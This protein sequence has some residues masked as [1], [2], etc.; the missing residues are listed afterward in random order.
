[1]RFAPSS[2]SGRLALGA[3]LMIGVALIISAIGIGFVLERFIRG[4]I[5]QRLDGQITSIASALAVEN[6]AL[7]LLTNVDSPPFDQPYSGW[8]W[9]VD[10]GAQKLR[11]ASLMAQDIWNPPAKRGRRQMLNGR[12]A[13]SDGRHG[14]DMHY[15]SQNLTIAGSDVTVTA[16]APRDALMGP[17]LQA[18]WP[19]GAS[20]LLLG[21]CLGLASKF[22]LR[23]GLRPLTALK[24]SLADVRNGRAT[25]IP[26]D[27][28]SELK[29]LVGE[30]NSL[31]D[32]NAEGLSRARL[33]VANL[34]H[35]LNTPLATLELSLREDKKGGEKRISLVRQMQERIRHHLGRARTAVL[36]GPARARTIIAPHIADIASA[37]GKIYADKNLRFESLIK[38]GLS[39]ACEPQDLDEMLGNIL[40]NSFKWAKSKVEITA[41]VSQGSVAL[42]LE[43]DGPG[44]ADDKLPQAL[45]PGRRLDESAPGS[46]FGLSI[47]RELAELYGG[48]IRLSRSELGGL[49]V[50]LV[51]PMAAA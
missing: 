15:R 9:Q 16:T 20:L 46:G 42:T 34:G 4:Q 33:H 35:A 13:P 28:P 38:P 3:V 31:I 14:D 27:Q 23:L 43:D 10:A 12:A 51:L 39:V 11:S 29:P 6:G 1:M 49:R 40:D 22:Q 45:L 7:K 18:L 37:L 41:S 26:A 24:N 47:T 2:I 48:N 50:E 8:Y 21:L 5:D 36:S 17:M 30:L 44:L 19:L 32:Q 25:H